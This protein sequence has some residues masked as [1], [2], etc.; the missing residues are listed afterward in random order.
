MDQNTLSHFPISDSFYRPKAGGVSSAQMPLNLSHGDIAYSY[1]SQGEMA[2]LD[3]DLKR[4]LSCFDA[5]LKL[6]STNSKLYYSQALSLFAFGE[7]SG[8]E[9]V[10][11]LAS[12]KFKAASQFHPDHFDTWLVWGSLL[13][14]LGIQ[15][16]AHHYFQEAKEKLAK[17]ISLSEGQE[18][19]ITSELQWNYGIACTHLAAHSGEASDWKEVMDAFQKAHDTEEKLPSKFWRD[20]GHAALQFAAYSNDIRFYSK[21]IQYL[22]NAVSLETNSFAS[23]KLLGESLEKL[24]LNTH[25]E[26]HFSQAN[27]CFA[28]AGQIEPQ[29]DGLWLKWAQFLCQA[30]RRA[31]DGKRLRLAIEKCQRA[32]ALNPKEPMIHAVWGEALALLGSYSERLDLIYDGQN[33]ISQ[34][35]ELEGDEPDICYSEGTC[36]QALGHYFD[37][38]DYYYQAIEKFQEGISIDRTRHRLWHAIGWTY[39]LLGDLE[40]NRETLELSLRFYQKALDLNASTYY[41]FDYATALFKLGEMT[42]QQHLL[43]EASVQFER[44]LH[45]Q[46]NAVYL[47]PDWLFQYACTLDALGDFHEEEFYYQ[48]AIEIFTHVLMIDPDL[49]HVHHSQALALSHL[50]ELSSDVEC[51][52]RAIHHFRL[53]MKNDEENDAALLDWASALINIAQHSYDTAEAEQLYRDAEHKL[54]TALR[55]GNLQAYYHFACLYSLKGECEKGMFCLDKAMESKALVP[56]EELLQDEWMET[57]RSTSDFQRFLNELEQKRNLQ[58]ER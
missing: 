2:L 41:L 47:H 9:K 35:T 53:A 25:D 14:T 32:F 20:W 7:G 39:A 16:K 30:A 26:D 55:L 58:E 22:K 13:L 52:Y 38:C 18:R 21:A 1:H 46:K 23:W 56:M 45:L 42:N 44:L 8:K 50:G 24:Y 17:A 29:N 51:F 48:R 33:K 5:A 31:A 27:D 37:E 11:L 40:N 4:A 15:T 43:E 34:A 10:L 49:Q 19:D 12:R 36:L 57:L 6:D 28:T 54:Q 3:G